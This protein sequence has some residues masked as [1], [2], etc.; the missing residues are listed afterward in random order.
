MYMSQGLCGGDICWKKS[1][2]VV[3][4]VHVLKKDWMKK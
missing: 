4:I 3:W 1:I 2:E